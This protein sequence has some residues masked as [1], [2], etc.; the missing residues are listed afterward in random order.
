MNI[1][2]IVVS[3][4]VQWK[5]LYTGYKQFYGV[6]VNETDLRTTFG[7]L[8]DEHH[9]QCGLVLEDNARLIG[10]ANYQ[11]QPNPLRATYR[12]YLN[13]MYVD[14]AYRGRGAGQQLLE[15]VI[16]IYQQG[17][18]ECLRWMT[19]QDNHAARALYDKYAKLSSFVTYEVR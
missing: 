11:R 7:W 4:F 16:A 1:R 3:D 10:L 2:P 18:Y 15:A 13:D 12:M 17:D 8:I 5:S 14:K 19:A 9:P 6:A